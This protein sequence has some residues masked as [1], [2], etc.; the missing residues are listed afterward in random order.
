MDRHGILYIGI[1]PFTVVGIEHSVEGLAN[2]NDER[3]LSLIGQ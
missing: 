3:Y 1:R 2:L